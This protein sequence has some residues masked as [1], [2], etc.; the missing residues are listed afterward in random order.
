MQKKIIYHIHT[1]RKFLNN[2]KRFDN[3]LF[4]NIIIYISFENLNNFDDYTI[5]NFY[6]A[7][8]NTSEVV[9]LVA[10]G[11]LV[12]FYGLCH[13]KVKILKKLPDKQKKIWRFFGYELYGKRKDLMFDKETYKLFEHRR[14]F[15]GTLFMWLRTLKRKY[16]NYRDE[17]LFK[18]FDYISMFCEEEYNFLLKYFKLPNLLLLNLME[19]D[20]PV[21]FN[22]NKKSTIILGNSRMPYNN[23]FEMLSIV[24]ES[25]T[26]HY[27]FK[28]LFNYGP[29]GTLSR[30]VE[31]RTK[32][33]NNVIIVNDFMTPKDFIEFYD[34]ASALVINSYRQMALGN[35][36]TGLKKGVK[37]Y[38]NDKNVI[39]K[40]LEDLGFI[41]SSIEN[42]KIDLETGNA[43]LSEKEMMHNA[44]LFKELPVRYTKTD[45][46]NK[47]T[48]LLAK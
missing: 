38:L 15:S 8:D 20:E 5:Y 34:D 25:C 1:D 42:L 41:I 47:V 26:P 37:I 19:Q 48:Q 27:N 7:L 13:L 9:E 14:G 32:S 35:I 31:D 11:D 18:K 2:T 22:T 43:S 33:I 16:S 4:T 46:N 24:Q 40:W 3:N 29:V 10:D 17:Q 23:H 39:K 28:L 44:T 21:R 6:A 36:F 30:A 45:F 12:V